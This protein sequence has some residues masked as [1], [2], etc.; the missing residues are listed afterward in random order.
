MNRVLLK[1]IACATLALFAVALPVYAQVYKCADSSGATVYSGKPCEYGGKSLPL[2]DNVVQGERL[3]P[4]VYGGG[5]TV[6]SSTGVSAECAQ[7]QGALED[8]SSKPTP[9][10]IVDSNRHRREAKQRSRGVEVACAG[11]GSNA[12]SQPQRAHGDHGPVT[13]TA[14]GSQ[15]TRSGSDSAECSRMQREL[16]DLLRTPAPTAITEANRHRQQVNQ[17]DRQYEV[18]CGSGSAG[19]SQESNAAN[20]TAENSGGT[21]RCPDGSVVSGSK[22]CL[23]C[24]DGSFVSGSSG[25]CQRAPNGRFV[26][27]NRKITRCPDGSFV[28]GTCWQ[29]PDGKFI[30]K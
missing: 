14:A 15:A 9:R 18:L 11:S 19:K 3:P 5:S 26:E 24:P 27:G 21:S 13:R 8:H 17:L 28:G 2:S 6:G 10:G 29:L 23:Q 12:S 4:P 16:L 1:A 7:A 25:S 20:G 30:G 22:G